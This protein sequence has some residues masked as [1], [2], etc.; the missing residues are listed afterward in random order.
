MVVLTSTLFGAA[1]L[2]I[3]LLGPLVFDSPPPGLTKARPVI[4]GLIVVAAL[5]LV[6]EWRGV[7]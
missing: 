3:L 5:A 1:G 6:L 7:H 2:A 4:V